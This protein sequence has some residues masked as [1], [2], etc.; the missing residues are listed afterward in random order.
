M[1]APVS[2]AVLQ[3]IIIEGRLVKLKTK[4]IKYK[5]FTEKKIKTLFYKFKGLIKIYFPSSA[6]PS[7]S[8]F[9]HNCLPTLWL[10]CVKISTIYLLSLSRYSPLTDR[11]INRVPLGFFGYEILKENCTQKKSKK[12]GT[13]YFNRKL[14]NSR[15]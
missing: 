4:P 14:I 9:N 12:V 10:Y 13:T 5:Y 3:I 2:T 1:L 7:T 15:Y 11:P 6:S 8:I